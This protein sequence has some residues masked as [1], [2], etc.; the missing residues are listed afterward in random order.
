MQ[1]KKEM[2]LKKHDNPDQQHAIHPGSQVW[3][4]DFVRS[5][6]LPEE[7]LV[8]HEIV[9]MPESALGDIS[10]VLKELATLPVELQELLRVLEDQNSSA[11]QV[12]KICEK[13]VAIS[14]MVLKLVNSPAFG[15][16]GKVDDLTQ[17]IK[18]IGFNELRS[19]V[20][21]MHTYNR[22]FKAAEVKDI[23]AL[24]EHSIASS[25]LGT[26]VAKNTNI[27]MRAGVMGTG[28][29]L[30]GIGKVFL[31]RWRPE[32]YKLAVKLSAEEGIT[33]MEAEN[34]AAGVT[35]ALVGA[36]MAEHWNLSRNIQY[37]IKACNLPELDVRLPE[38]AAIHLSGQIA[39]TELGFS[40][41]EP[42]NDTIPDSICEFLNLEHRT[43]SELCAQGRF[44]EFVSLH[45]PDA[46]LE[47]ADAEGEID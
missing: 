28:G 44:K 11:A 33:L 20:L 23:K 27:S 26:W 14:T 19:L 17:A 8:Y 43:V 41:G 42:P 18:Y 15:L 37:I 5:K 47:I 25:K 22:Y 3:D 4:S 21:G 24:W 13:S 46:H 30:R 12:G 36:M 32:K 16:F 40:D 10:Y 9:N 31:M 39:R 2:D 45:I 35:H 7:N 38:L 1:Q 29:M 34:R 6:F